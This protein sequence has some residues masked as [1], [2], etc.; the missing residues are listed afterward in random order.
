MDEE[1]GLTATR[2]VTVPCPLCADLDRRIWFRAEIDAAGAFPIV[3]D[4]T[5]RPHAAVFGE[6]NVRSWKEKRG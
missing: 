4:L 3:A 2:V 1:A 5:G 6:L